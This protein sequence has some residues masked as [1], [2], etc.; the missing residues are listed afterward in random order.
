MTAMKSVSTRCMKLADDG[1]DINSHLKVKLSLPQF[2]Y[3][4]SV[5][6]PSEST[7]EKIYD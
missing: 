2:F 7:D 5:L 3:V 4:A 1:H 6:D